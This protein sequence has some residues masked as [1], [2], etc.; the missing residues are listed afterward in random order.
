MVSALSKFLEKVADVTAEVD[1]MSPDGPD[2]AA[3]HKKSEQLQ[4]LLTGCDHHHQ[5]AKAARTRF[6]A[7]TA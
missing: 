1:L 2:D 3:Y 4:A 5:G 7:L 6:Q